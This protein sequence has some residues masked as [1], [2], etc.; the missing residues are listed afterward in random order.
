MTGMKNRFTLPVLCCIVVFPLG[1]F[2]GIW[3]DW[4]TWLASPT[5]QAIHYEVEPYNQANLIVTAGDY[6]YLQHPDGTSHQLKMNFKGGDAP[7]Q[8]GNGNDYCQIKDSKT[9]GEY[10]FSCDSANGDT[11]PDPGMQQQPT[12]PSN[13]NPI[14]TSFERA[15]AADIKHLCGLSP[16]LRKAEESPNSATGPQANLSSSST[17]GAYAYV[18]CNT[19]NQTEVVPRQPPG[20]AD[21]DISIPTGQTIYWTTHSVLALTLPAGLC[22]SGTLNSNSAKTVWWCVVGA[23]NTYTYTAA[24]EGCTKPSPD[25]HIIVTGSVK[26]KK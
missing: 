7:C 21:S 9:G 5:P 4:S 24:L 25:E 26:N 10:L 14:P 19:S 11:C 1:L 8:N 20:K 17:V 18:D 12:N 6:V 15:F 13:P 2:V 3:A 23:P 22:N 16:S